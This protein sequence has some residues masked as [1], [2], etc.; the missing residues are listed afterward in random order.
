MNRN[1]IEICE[2]EMHFNFNFNFNLIH[3]I[4]IYNFTIVSTRVQESLIEA[5]EETYKFKERKGKKKKEIF[6][7]QY[8][9]SQNK[10]L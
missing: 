2:F 9:L 10:K 3:S 7:K 4:S 6:Y 5:G 1:E 8:K